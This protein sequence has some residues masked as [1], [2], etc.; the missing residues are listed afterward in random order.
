MM[1]MHI[2]ISIERLMWAA[3]HVP[4]TPNIVRTPHHEP[5][6]SY[7]ALGLELGYVFGKPH[8]KSRNSC[9]ALGISWRG[10]CHRAVRSDHGW[11]YS[12]EQWRSKVAYGWNA[13]HSVVLTHGMH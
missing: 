11:V 8:Y 7:T 5:R 1:A 3:A 6:N 4:V 9:T 13:G 12:S 10:C 2:D